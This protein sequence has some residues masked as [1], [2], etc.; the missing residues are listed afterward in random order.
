M[1]DWI[2]FVVRPSIIE[3]YKQGV[4]KDG[5]SK[6]YEIHEIPTSSP[7]LS[8]TFVNP[9]R[10]PSQYTTVTSCSRHR[11]KE[12]KFHVRFEI[13]LKLN[14]FLIITFCFNLEIQVT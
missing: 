7:Q 3:L 14:D 13:T 6:E 11:V 4:L 9:A 2:T 5:H 10:P 1:F 8:Q 12:T